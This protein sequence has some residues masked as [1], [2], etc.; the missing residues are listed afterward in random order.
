MNQTVKTLAA[1]ALIAA[2]AISLG[3]AE[4]SAAAAPAPT[5]TV[6]EAAHFDAKPFCIDVCPEPTAKL[7][8]TGVHVAR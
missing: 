6:G 4:T 5:Q 1:T 8:G 3:G 2:T 7:A